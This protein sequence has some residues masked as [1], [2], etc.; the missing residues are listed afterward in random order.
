MRVRSKMSSPP[1]TPGGSQWRKIGALGRGFAGAQIRFRAEAGLGLAIF[2]SGAVVALAHAG[3]LRAADGLCPG[4]GGT[5]G[6]VVSVDERLEL[7]LENGIRLKIAGVDPPRPTPGAPDLD[8]RA[9][10]RLAGWLVGQ[11]ILFRPLE[12]DPDRWGRV[13]AFVFAVAPESTNGPG[14]AHMPVGEALIDAG[15]ARYEPSAAA[16]PCRS[17]LLAAEASARASGLGLWADPYYAIVA[18]ADRLSFAEKAGSSI[19]VEGRITG[20]ASR[21]PR[22][23]LYFGPRQGWDFSVTILPRNSKTFEA[24]YSSLARLTGQTVRVRGLLDTR[25]GPQIEISDQDEVE[26]AGQGQDAAAGSPAPR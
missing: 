14:P 9:R 25:F 3:G 2:F 7:T 4:E 24:V 22:I 5:S 16:R 26:A 6:R 20:I 1:D 19:I 13:V 21:R 12:P 17:A 23:T 18:A 8:V 15:I 10:D 11:E